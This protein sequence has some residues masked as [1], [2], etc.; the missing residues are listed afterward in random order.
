MNSSKITLPLSNL[1]FISPF[2]KH[3]K[4]M[5]WRDSWMEPFQTQYNTNFPKLKS[6]V[7][8]KKNLSPILIS[9]LEYE[10]TKDMIIHVLYM[11]ERPS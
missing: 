3:R 2:D 4:S 6:L 11:Y 8:N 5:V 7:R 10:V 9:I 1:Y